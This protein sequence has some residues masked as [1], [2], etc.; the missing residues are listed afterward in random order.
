MAT[1]RFT[2]TSDSEKKT[3]PQM[4][5][6]NADKGAESTEGRKVEEPPGVVRSDPSVICLHRLHL[7]ITRLCFFSSIPSAFLCVICG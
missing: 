7:R 1:N 4:T 6:M 2:T 5:Q 3:H